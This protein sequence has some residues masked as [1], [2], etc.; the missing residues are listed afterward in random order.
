MGTAS[1]TAERQAPPFW[2]STAGKLLIQTCGKC[3]EAFHYPRSVCPFCLSDEVGW[4]ECSGDG[5]IYSYSV[6]RRGAPYVLAIVTLAEG[7]RLLTNVVDCDVDALTIGQAVS[8]RFEDVDGVATP[9]FAPL[10]PATAR[11]RDFGGFH[12]NNL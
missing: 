2:H 3:R 1:I 7:P 9:M 11:I 8:V 5:V 4:T 12:D 10:D 6:F